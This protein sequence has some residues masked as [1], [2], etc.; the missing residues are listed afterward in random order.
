MLLL[1]IKKKSVIPAL[2]RMRQENYTFES[3]L[4]CKVRQSQDEEKSIERF[5][6][7]V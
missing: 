2:R 4:G 3:R 7:R 1:N 6:A 5:F